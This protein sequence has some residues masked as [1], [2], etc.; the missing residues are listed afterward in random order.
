MQESQSDKKLQT[1]EII[2]FPNNHNFNKSTGDFVKCSVVDLWSMYIK[3]SKEKH[4]LALTLYGCWTGH[5]NYEDCYTI[6]QNGMYLFPA[7]SKVGK[8][9][10][11]N[12]VLS[13][14]E[15]NNYGLTQ[16]GIAYLRAYLSKNHEKAKKI[17]V[18]LV[19]IYQLAISNDVDKRKKIEIIYQSMY[20]DQD[21]VAYIKAYDSLD[22]YA[23]EK[24]SGKTN[25][26]Q[27]NKLLEDNRTKE[28]I[29]NKEKIK[30]SEIA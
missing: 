14:V 20:Q 7:T 8:Y 27:M 26:I 21:L 19:E 6:D 29:R 13:M 15:E 16:L 23:S 24:A 4:P 10:Q 18:Y 11:D 30:E 17:K 3:A 12:L 1:E 9:L 28:I 25:A 5:R 2:P 22:G